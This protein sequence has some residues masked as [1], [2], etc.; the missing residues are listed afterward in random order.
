[1]QN[2]GFLRVVPWGAAVADTRAVS[3]RGIP[4]AKKPLK[5]EKREKVKKEKKEI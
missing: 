1:L 5:K 4:V 2:Q 3:E